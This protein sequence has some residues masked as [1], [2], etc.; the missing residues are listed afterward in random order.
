[1]NTFVTTSRKNAWNRKQPAESA[2]T[3]PLVSTP[4]RFGSVPVS[5][6]GQSAPSASQVARIA[7]AAVR[8]A[9]SPVV[10][11]EP[12]YVAKN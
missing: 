8:S 2:G 11:S 4:D 3:V 7:F 6:V 5:P 10:G 1:M 9:E 12:M